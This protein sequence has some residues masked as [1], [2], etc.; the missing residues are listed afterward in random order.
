MV[1]ED[2]VGT[3]F[4][5]T[6]F[7]ALLVT[8][9][10]PPWTKFRCPLLAKPCFGDLISPLVLTVSRSFLER[11]AIVLSYVVYFQLSRSGSSLLSLFVV[12]KFELSS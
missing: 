3:C 10:V 1:S 9:R 7:A 5:S 11:T 12:Y 4:V 6:V 8:L 2:E